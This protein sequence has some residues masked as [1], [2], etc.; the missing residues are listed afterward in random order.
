LWWD[1]TYIDG[2]EVK[3][4][5]SKPNH[6]G[7][8][9]DCYSGEVM[10]AHRD[11][12]AD[13]AAEVEAKREEMIAAGAQWFS[14]NCKDRHGETFAIDILAFNHDEAR[15]EALENTSI[16]EVIDVMTQEEIEAQ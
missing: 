14:V 12:M 5:T 4:L 3:H 9:M 11:A 1:N 16:A 15:K 8:N 6:Q 10:N 7:E 2:A 13:H